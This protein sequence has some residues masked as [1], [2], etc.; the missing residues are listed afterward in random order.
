V[1]PVVTIDAPAAST[2]LI[3]GVDYVV[4][5]AIVDEGITPPRTSTDISY[6]QWF[7][8]AGKPLA[9]ATTAPY[10]YVLRIANGITSVTLKAS[11][12]DLSGNV[13]NILPRRRRR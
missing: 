11:A 6:V 7:D 12:V 13:S 1:R 10:G 9:K 5:V 3:A 4:T 8:S 2:K